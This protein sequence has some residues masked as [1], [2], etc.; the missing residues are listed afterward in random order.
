MTFTL[1]AKIAV[2]RLFREQRRLTTKFQNAVVA[3]NASVSANGYPNGRARQE[4]HFQVA[5]ELE[6]QVNAAGAFAIVADGTPDRLKLKSSKGYSVTAYALWPIGLGQ[7]GRVVADAYMEEAL[8]L[9]RIHVEVTL[10]K[11]V[12][13]EAP[14]CLALTRHAIERMYDRCELDQ[15]GLFG[16]AANTA[17]AMI[18]PLSLITSNDL[19]KS[20]SNDAG[21]NSTAAVPLMAGCLF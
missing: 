16:A 10:S 4:A 11:F 7:K 3:L 1:P 2:D 6:R 15:D 20:K 12:V 8:M 9:F 13:S 19:T 18:R 17:L 5:L 14:L 21:F